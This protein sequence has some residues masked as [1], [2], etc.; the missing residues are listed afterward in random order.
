MN[1]ALWSYAL[2][3]FLALS[4]VKLFGNNFN[5][6]AKRKYNLEKI[7]TPTLYKNEINKSQLVLITKSKSYIKKPTSS[8]TLLELENFSSEYHGY[9]YNFE[10]YNQ[11][12]SV[13]T[14]LILPVVFSAGGALWSVSQDHNYP[15]FHVLWAVVGFGV[16]ELVNK[17]VFND[18]LL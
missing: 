11:I 12:K 14:L 17:F 6:Y 7:K 13:G 5:L 8:R 3:L 15:V 2:V 10:K 9:E 1:K 16:G 18:T 4:C